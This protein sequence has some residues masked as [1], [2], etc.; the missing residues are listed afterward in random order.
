VFPESTS[1]IVNVLATR[2]KLGMP[3]EIFDFTGWYMSSDIP[4][5]P[6]MLEEIHGLKVVWREEGSGLREYIC[7]SGRPQELDAIRNSIV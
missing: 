5:D 2:R 4:M 1:L 7:G 3:I 6:R